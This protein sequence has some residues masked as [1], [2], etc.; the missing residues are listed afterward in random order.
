M[1]LEI[2]QH[3]LICGGRGNP[4]C[5]SCRMFQVH[6]RAACLRMLLSGPSSNCPCWKL[7]RKTSV[8]EQVE[9]SVKIRRNI[10]SQCIL[11][12]V[13]SQQLYSSTPTFPICNYSRF[14]LKAVTNPI[15]RATVRMPRNHFLI[16]SLYL[17]LVICILEHP[18]FLFSSLVF[19][20]L[21]HFQTANISHFCFC[22]VKLNKSFPSISYCK[23]GLLLI[24]LTALFCIYQF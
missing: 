10:S 8:L 13:S 1:W 3:D 7:C 20:H 16:S 24:F 23:A 18:W 2:H 14:I 22:F 4:K 12:Q 15:C 9:I 11:Q 21:I 5:P 19:T 17:F 6:R